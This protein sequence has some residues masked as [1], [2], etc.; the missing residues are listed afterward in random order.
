MI[1]SKIKIPRAGILRQPGGFLISNPRSAKLAK[2][3][4]HTPDLINLYVV[5]KL[6]FHRM[7]P[8]AYSVHFVQG[9]VFDPHIDDILRENVALQQ[10]LVVF[11]ERL[12]GFIERSR[13]RWNFCQ[14]FRTQCVD[15]RIERL[16]RVDPVF[17]TVKGGHKQGGETEVAVA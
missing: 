14:L 1:L 9:L 15:V 8:Q 10:E 16:A 17:D 7:R 5:V 2:A 4:T 3:G 11:C 13:S 12:E 6:E